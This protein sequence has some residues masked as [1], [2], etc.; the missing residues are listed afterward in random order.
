MSRPAPSSPPATRLLRSSVLVAALAGVLA[1]A[2]VG[3]LAPG[4]AVLLGCLVVGAALAPEA[5]PSPGAARV[6]RAVSVV[7]ISAAGL[8]AATVDRPLDS[9]AAIANLPGQLGPRLALLAVGLLIAQLLLSD[10]QREVLVSLLV[11]GGLFVFALAADPGPAAGV[12]LLVGWP[13]AVVA[14]VAAHAQSQ[15][16][17][18]DV[19]AKVEGATPRAPVGP[20][21]LVTLVV[22]SA[23]VAVLVVLLGPHPQGLQPGRRVGAAGPDGS[24]AAGGSGRD[25]AAY[26]HGDLDLR[27]RGRLPDVAVAEVPLDSP[28]LW[29][30]ATLPVYDGTT[31]RSTNPGSV[32][33][34]PL[35]NG[36]PYTLA[37]D[38]GDVTS[39]VRADQLRV[40]EGF[41]G[42][43]LA[44]GH[45][46]TLD[47]A[48]RVFPISGGYFLAEASQ[49]G[50]ATS[51]VVTSSPTQRPAEMLRAATPQPTAV[52]D[53]SLYTALPDTVPARV[54]N[55]GRRL[56]AAA[57]TRYDATVAVERYLRS[58]ATYRLDSPVPPPG[59]DAVDH[60][61]FTAHTGFCEQFASAEVVL[62]RA[63]G[64][65]ARLA[66]GFAGGTVEGGHRTLRGTDAH[67][68]VEVL[69]PGL[70]WEASDPTAGTRL[71][72]TPDAR[73]RLAQLLRDAKG[74]AVLAVLV[75]AASGLG[76]GAAW[77]LG[78]WLRRR[79]LRTQR[80]TRELAPVLAAFGRLEA[81]LATAGAPRAAAESISELARRP[82]L[83]AVAG[84]LS[85]VE[86][87]CY[88]P[89]PPSGPDG[90]EAVR[91][92][93]ELSR[94]LLA[95]A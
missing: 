55:L 32:L 14:L 21:S 23:V 25:M 28:S 63:A 3:L 54:R 73:H 76:W 30:G 84:A 61:L 92:L 70:G 56:T 78:R 42:V 17:A 66:T 22:G 46:V 57:T 7:A 52:A 95:D 72:T 41:G 74:R 68:W 53:T 33:G 16:A 88:A 38:L 2:S 93:D 91:A 67:A 81:A 39:S 45:P 83:A 77:L 24:P 71:A 9:A 4:V 10:R 31:W 87:T 58:H 90:Q 79:G 48:G 35:R 60:F 59:V 64:I 18:T 82:G 36:P 8:A 85:V 34:P 15:R 5:F 43:L 19:T 75:V 50:G 12:A 89:A 62:L 29:L 49:A 26:T 1:L 13:A 27:T 37:R 47:V 69:Y 86:R 51:Y 94:E 80:R 40:R 6:R 44:P 20:G 11:G 65:P